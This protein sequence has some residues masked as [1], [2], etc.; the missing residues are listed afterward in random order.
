MWIQVH[1]FVA[2]KSDE[3]ERM[4][5]LAAYD[6]ETV[7]VRKDFFDAVNVID[8]HMLAA[9]PHRNEDDD[10]LPFD[11]GITGAQI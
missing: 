4:S 5:G 7:L 6:S 3:V 1:Q 11:F 8:V 10:R 2:L 9:Q